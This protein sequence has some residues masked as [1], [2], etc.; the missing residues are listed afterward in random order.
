MIV[1]LLV[2]LSSDFIGLARVVVAIGALD[3]VGQ[4]GGSGGLR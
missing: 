4:I 1:G 2:V 3:V